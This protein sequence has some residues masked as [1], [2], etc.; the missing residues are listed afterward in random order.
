MTAERHGVFLDAKTIACELVKPASLA[1]WDVHPLVPPAAVAAS[2]ANA[3]VAYT[4]KVPLGAESL[5]GAGRLELIVVAATGYDIIDLACCKERGVAVANSPGYS[6]SSVP[7]HVL[8]LIF[9]AA[10]GVVPYHAAAGD[11]TWAAADIFCLQRHPII[12]LRGR[13]AGFIG[14]GSLGRASAALCASV[15]MKTVF[16][17]RHDG[18]EDE[19]PRLGLDELLATS[20]VV[21]LHCPLTPAN[22]GMIDA[23]ALA[24]M[25]DGAILIN[26]ARGAL[27]D[28]AALVAALE[29]GKL[30]G[31]GIDVLA[32]EPPPAAEPLLNCSHPGLVLSPHVAW[33]SMESQQRLARMLAATTDAF[34]SGA[35][36]HLVG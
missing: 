20:D 32:A 29:A 12:E 5:A 25:K 36:R 17:A 3:H 15:G 19:L 27:V 33:A 26:T 21:S 16:L 11:G 18:K 22:R 14:S 34:F 24:R 9:A 28:S 13:Q 35:P 31:A 7:E 4:N 23:A 30:R 1:S 2:I 10:R 8:A 6:A